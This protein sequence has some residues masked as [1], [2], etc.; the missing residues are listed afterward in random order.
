MER[1]PYDDVTFHPH[2]FGDPDGRLFWWQGELYRGIKDERAD[3]F[4]RLFDHGVI[5]KLAAQKL[6]IESEP[7]GLA[8]DGYAMVIRHRCVPFVSYP[9]EW[10]A[11]MFKDAARAY[12]DLI[13]ELVPQGL[14][15]R[16][17]HPWNLLFDGCS[18]VYVDLT[19]I[20]SMPPSGQCIVHD[21]Y[22]RYYLYPLLLMAHGQERIAR[23]LLPDY[24][25]ISSEEF[26]L[27][28]GQP[29]PTARMAL[30]DRVK[31]AVPDSYR[32]RLKRG[33]ESFGLL[34]SR[35]ARQRSQLD[36]LLTLRSELESIRLPAVDDDRSEA[37]SILFSQ[38]LSASVP[39]RL[40]R[41]IAELQPG[42]ILT[43]GAARRV[44]SRLA[45]LAQRRVVAFDKDSTRVTRLYY[46]GRD[47]NLPLLPLVMDFIDPTPSRGLQS[48]LCMAA[49]QR[50]QCD[51]V[52]PFGL[53]DRMVERSLRFDQVVDGLAQFARRYL[54]VDS[55]PLKA[56]ERK[57]KSYSWYTAENFINALSKKFRKIR[58][59]SAHARDGG[60]LVC[61]R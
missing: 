2:S 44:S 38:D 51:M 10:C 29:R 7:T 54:I 27:L 55:V 23:H 58:S 11:A 12:L 28:M 5:E 46:D 9:Q 47:K 48:H 60:L 8:L 25:G 17:T 37:D 42:S 20:R 53:I 36:C 35:K 15:L 43:I 24:E 32:E 56:D 45:T 22:R 57:L 6:L 31:R 41:I 49:A 1:I 18:P 33:L 59:C 3:F 61:E 40:E 52:L 16:D 34:H 21:K 26:S 14:T 30:K 4:K 39:E 50:L 19:S 13:A